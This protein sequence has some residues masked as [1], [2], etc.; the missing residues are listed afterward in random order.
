MSNQS[1]NACVQ[2]GRPRKLTPS[3]H[4]ST[5]PSPRPSTPPSLQPSGRPAT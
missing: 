5:P 4:P 2:W 3:I 1:L